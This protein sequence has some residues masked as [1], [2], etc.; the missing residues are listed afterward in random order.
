MVRIKYEAPR[1]AD[2]GSIAEHTF[3][4]CP[5]GNAGASMPK[6]PENMELDKFGE[7]SHS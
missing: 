3:Y 5:A 7:C 2:L 6:N 1:V 4:R